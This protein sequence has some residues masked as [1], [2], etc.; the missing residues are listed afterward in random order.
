MAKVTV[1]F[2]KEEVKYSGFLEDYT[3]NDLFEMALAKQEKRCDFTPDR[4]EEMD[5]EEAKKFDGY[6]SFE[7]HPCN[8]LTVVKWAYIRE[9]SEDS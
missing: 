3:I 5:E 4:S 7:D 8:R 2:W 9:E 6:I 1:D